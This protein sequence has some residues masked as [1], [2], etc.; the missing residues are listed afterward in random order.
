MSTKLEKITVH[1]R[2]DSIHCGNVIN[3][4]VDNLKIDQLSMPG[5]TFTRFIKHEE[6]RL[7]L[8]P[9]DLNKNVDYLFVHCGT[10]DISIRN[11]D[12]RNEERFPA[13]REMMKKYFEFY[14]KRTQKFLIEILPRFDESKEKRDLFVKFMATNE[15]D[16]VTT[17][18]YNFEFK[19]KHFKD[20]LHLKD[21]FKTGEFFEMTKN[22]VMKVIEKQF[23]L[24]DDL[25]NIEDKQVFIL[26]RRENVWQN[27]KGFEKISET[28]KIINSPKKVIESDSM[29]T[30]EY[31]VE[32][33]NMNTVTKT[34]KSPM[35]YDLNQDLNV[36]D[37]N[38][39]FQPWTPVMM[40][41]VHPN[42]VITHNPF[43]TQTIVTNN[44]VILPPVMTV[45]EVTQM[46][47]ETILNIENYSIM[48]EKVND[49]NAYDGEHTFKFVCPN[50]AQSCNLI[51]SAGAY[52]R[53]IRSLRNFGVVEFSIHK[54][55]ITDVNEVPAHFP[56]KYARVKNLLQVGKIVLTDLSYKDIFQAL[57][58]I[59]MRT[60]PSNQTARQHV[61]KLFEMAHFVY[62]CPNYR[63]NPLYRNYN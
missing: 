6:K 63:L 12:Y 5:A 29:N 56:P 23:Q 30:T 60:P 14:P 21:L 49:P 18:R 7:Q 41:L 40:D 37:F 15:I 13:I 53:E 44:E 28:K 39:N 4:E 52:C 33:I 26:I 24:E 1:F 8:E 16:G 45:T 51:G 54:Q 22:L 9:A 58:N 48:F 59:M 2:T 27:I 61:R 35:Y 20:R 19:E 38:N 34:E 46:E 36:N 62:Y 42:P 50:L 10:N 17:L 32:K 3:F 25:L 47:I 31:Q 57:V 11:G 55:E 43:H